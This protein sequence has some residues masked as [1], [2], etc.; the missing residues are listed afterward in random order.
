MPPSREKTVMKIDP[1]PVIVPDNERQPVLQLALSRAEDVVR[2]IRAATAGVGGVA[3]QKMTAALIADA[4][5]AVYYEGR[6]T[7][8]LRHYEGWARATRWRLVWWLG[9]G[10]ALALAAAAGILLRA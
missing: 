2:K 5:E 3:G 6:T 9:G 8:L 7:S 10:L 4:L 1:I